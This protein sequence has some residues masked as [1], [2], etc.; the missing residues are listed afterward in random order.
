VDLFA[1]FTLL[2]RQ[3]G[4]APDAEAI[5]DALWFAQFHPPS[6]GRKTG[7]DDVSSR[8]PIRHFNYRALQTFK[9]CVVRLW[10]KTLS[11]FP[12]DEPSPS[13]FALKADERAPW[14]QPTVVEPT[15]N[16]AS[17]NRL[18]AGPSAGDTRGWRASPV[19]APATSALPGA[20][21]VARAFRPFSR[22]FPSAHRWILDEEGTAESFAQFRF[23]RPIVRPVPERWLDVALVVDGSRSMDVWRK[24]IKEL[25]ELLAGHGAFG[26]VRRWR[27][28]GNARI[29]LESAGGQT[30]TPFALEDPR[31]RTL[32]LIVTNGVGAFWGGDA[33][34][35]VLAGWSRRAP[36]AVLQLFSERQWPH[37][38]LGP[39]SRL[40][41]A[42]VPGTSNERLKIARK[43]W[44]RTLEGHN[45]TV[46]PMLSLAPESIARWAAS[47]M[48]MGLTPTPAVVFAPGTSS[49]GNDV[50]A[51]EPEE[52][53]A[54]RLVERFRS[55]ASAEAFRLIGYLATVP[56][57]LPIMR[58]IQQQI[59]RAPRVEH[60]A[61]VMASGLVQR[62]TPVD[63]EVDPDTVVYGF[64]DD[65]LD[66]LLSTL[67]IGTVF[68]VRAKVQ[69]KLKEFIERQLGRSIGN[70][71]AFVLDE[72][73]QYELPAG[74][75]AFVEIERGLLTKLGLR[76]SL[77][78]PPRN[79]KQPWPDEDIWEDLLAGIE[80]ERV[81]PIIGPALST[82][83]AGGRQISLES[84]V[85]ERLAP[86]LGL[87]SDALPPDPTL[88]EVVSLYLRRN[89]RREALY[90]RIRSIVQEAAFTPPKVLRQLAEIGQFN[91]YVSTAFDPLLEAAINEV[92]FGGAPRTQTIAYA[93]NNVRDLE[94]D[95][96]HLTMPTVYYLFGRVSAAPS[97][98]ISDEDQLELL[99]ALQ[100]E[101]LRP[102][103]LFDE[104]ENNH[105]LIIGCNFSDWVTRIF[106][107]SARRRRLSDPR[108][109]LEVLADD[110]SGKDPG[111]VAFLA[112]FSPRTKIFYV[113]A[114]T[115]VEALSQRWRERAGDKGGAKQTQWMPPEQ[116]DAD[117]TADAA[118]SR[119]RMPESTLPA[120][121]RFWFPTGATAPSVGARG[122][123]G[124]PLWDE[125]IWEEL[126]AYI[127][128]ER[129]IP[130]VGP[131]L[132]TVIAEGRSISLESYVA[133][134]LAPRLG[135][136][137]DALPAAPTLNEVVS[138][139]LRRNGR[140]EALYPRIRSIVQ[141]AALTPP[142]VLRQLA[143]IS[144]FN[145]FVTATF[146]PLLEAAI[147]EVRFGG[148]ARTQTIAYA[149]NN[150]RDLETSKRSLIAPTVFHLL[151]KLSASPSYAVSDEDLLE[152]L[153]ALQSE[154]QRPERLFDELENNHLLIVGGNFSD[155]VARIFL[156]TAKR[157][158]L[159]DPREVLEIL[160]DDRSGNDPGLVAFLA[161]FSPRTKVFHAGAEAFVDALSSRWRDRFGKQG[162][163]ETVH[164]E[165]PAGEMPDGAIFISYAR[166]DLAAVRALKEALEEAELTVWFDF[167]RI[168]AGDTFD[169]KIQSNIRRCSLFLPVLSRNTEARTEGFFRRE[170]N[171]ALERDKRIG[172]GIPFIIPV[173]IDDNPRLATV[174]R[175]FREINVTKLVGGRPSPDFVEQLKRIRGGR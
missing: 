158:R 89:G 161:N 36:V 35:H 77:S 32:I 59:D 93:P 102:A 42:A 98:A 22:R 95:S 28:L 172:Q 61:E 18:F 169:P 92:R 132:S 164:R 167:E 3:A 44:E 165:L 87:P 147:N 24:T 171:Y 175:R 118:A 146:D 83:A 53:N 130:I 131:A 11:G 20:L 108:E 34:A 75:Q 157:R 71:R 62:L 105:L 17:D 136:P 21:D 69:A 78:R 111:L 52:L 54:G 148:A 7:A 94:T 66:V 4:L 109:V 90:P 116:L 43:P 48:A 141:E 80:E 123:T 124:E 15:A 135:L 10:R 159:S 120:D 144:H 40:V 127:E 58:I 41:R 82:V 152:F 5:A 155:W 30:R 153:N 154:S 173:A 114:E 140:R 6:D 99:Y 67:R 26:Q 115:F 72:A 12:D 84:Y 134:R 88:N 160:A 117:E 31:G 23:I 121:Q 9:E 166:E 74:A 45:L 47:A 33:I 68:D 110:R 113:G 79:F 129:V 174:P 143:E 38:V 151:G 46:V 104:L 107:R 97:Y 13:A 70:F 96:R 85:A 65:V 106:L 86:R 100:S 19:H 16:Y 73:G 56:L 142:K 112:N 27:L 50:T 133:E 137:S 91:L 1:D 8:S 29:S 126:L 145:L 156:R 76:R 168:G 101:S 163:S 37:T 60:L 64:S 57:T 63:A 51:S 55:I 49:D 14:D 2:L 150:V 149:P 81:I 138:L 170:W 139:Y 128:E 25:V 119:D 39:P 122:I 162:G 103:R 125:D